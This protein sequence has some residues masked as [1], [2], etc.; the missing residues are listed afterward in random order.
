MPKQPSSASWYSDWRACCGGSPCDRHETALF[1]SVNIEPDKSD[2]GH[3]P[4]S[5]VRPTD[6]P[7]KNHLFM[8]VPRQSD[9]AEEGAPHRKRGLVDGFFRLTALPTFPL[10]RLS[11]YEHLL[12]GK[13]ARLSSRWS[14]CAVAGKCRI[15]PARHSRSVEPLPMESSEDPH[16]L[17]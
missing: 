10:D 5:L 6:V 2:N 13:P 12:C 17:I 1:E 9:T 15:I 4:L 14:Q 3:P 16:G 8:G 11:R 7:Q